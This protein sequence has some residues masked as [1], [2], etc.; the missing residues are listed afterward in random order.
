MRP[1][2]LKHEGRPEIAIA[3]DIATL[4]ALKADGWQVVAHPVTAKEGEAKK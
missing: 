1:I 2:S 3:R 4:N